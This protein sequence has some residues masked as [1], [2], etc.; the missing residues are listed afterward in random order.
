MPSVVRLLG[1]RSLWVLPPPAEHVLV[2]ASF[3]SVLLAGSCSL[4]LPC[5][6]EILGYICIVKLV[7]AVQESQE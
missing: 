6:G 4:V 3:A 1:L 7:T 2:A 5:N